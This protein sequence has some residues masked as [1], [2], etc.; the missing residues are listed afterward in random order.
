MIRIGSAFLMSLATAAPLRAGEWAYRPFERPPFTYTADFALRFWFGRTN[1]AKNL[2]DISGAYLVS[3]LTYGDLAIFAA[4]AYTRFDFDRRWF[5]KGYV[6]G[7][8]LR[9][10]SLKDED[11]PPVIA[12]YSATLSV[13]ENGTP[14]YGS[15][16]IGVN[17]I[18]GPDWR[19][20][21]FGGLHYMNQNVSAFGCTQISFNPSICGPSPIPNPIEVITQNNNWYSV[22]LGIDG[23]VELG[24]FRFSGE[25]AWLPSVRVYGSDAHWLRIGNFP[26]DF[27]GPIPEDGKGSGFQ[28]EGFIAYRVIDGVSVG[29]GGRYWHMQTRGQTHFEQHIIGFP[30]LPQPVEWRTDNLGFFLQLNVKA[31]PY[32][33]IDVR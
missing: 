20:G 12:P 11:F 2:Y 31:G 33:A 1:T 29:I 32:A 3:R 28:L 13:Q 26:G 5:V 21:L 22:R 30:A 16:D 25:A 24:R 8:T 7:G 15:G 4:E 10:G 9:K 23:A 27:S 6:G 18:F 17:V 19:I 14:I